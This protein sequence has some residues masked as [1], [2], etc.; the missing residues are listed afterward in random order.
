MLTLHTPRPA[1]SQPYPPP[2]MDS[3]AEAYDAAAAAAQGGYVGAG[4]FHLPATLSPLVSPFGISMAGPGGPLSPLNVPIMYGVAPDGTPLPPQA[5][6][7]AA[8][9]AMYAAAVMSPPAV[10]AA[11]AAAAAAVAAGGGMYAPYGAEA[12]GQAEVRASL[13]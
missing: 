3:M 12:P 4:A 9:A 10:A 13:S 8:A 6:D 5:F 11:A 1:T 7:P 2:Y